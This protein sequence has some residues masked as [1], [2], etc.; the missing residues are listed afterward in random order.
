MLPKPQK[1]IA[2]TF[3]L[4]E[5][6]INSK[7]C[8]ELVENDTVG[9]LSE[10][11]SATEFF[12]ENFFKISD[13]INNLVGAEVPLT[14]FIRADKHVFNE[15]GS[16]DYF[17]EKYI[18]KLLQYQSL[19]HEIGLHL[20]LSESDWVN[21][22]KIENDLSELKKF[23]N[24]EGLNLHGIRFGGHNLAEKFV[25]MLEE[26]G[27]VYDSSMMP[28]RKRKDKYFNFDWTRTNKNIH[29]I[30]ASDFNCKN[31]HT[32]DLLE[33]PFTMF[34]IKAPYDLMPIQR[35]FDLNFAN[36]CIINSINN[37]K[38]YTLAIAHPHSTIVLQ[39]HEQNSLMSSGWDNFEKNLEF[40]KFKFS[41]FRFDT[42]SNFAKEF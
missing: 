41:E 35:Y 17:F 37:D 14:L 6:P 4:D 20:H 2:L 16:R 21:D 34:K 31:H 24:Q 25:P 11:W 12:L 27:F 33:I 28:G 38:S 1:K 22:L 40:I 13:R 42:L 10:K 15:Y 3:D 32:Y 9:L 5:N 36:E 29:K 30:N 18:P 23:A 26:L 39:E 7:I 8:E 19:G